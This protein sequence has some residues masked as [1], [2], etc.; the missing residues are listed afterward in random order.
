VKVL[1]PELSANQQLQCRFETEAQA[2]AKLQHPNIVQ[3][4]DFGQDTDNSLFIAMEFIDGQ[5]LRAVL[6]AEAPLRPARA[7]HIA[8]Q[9][10]ASL[11]EAHSHKIIHRD[12]KPDNVMLQQKGR[13]RD[14]AR[15]LDFGIA[16][17]RD[18]SRQTEATMT[19]AGDMLGTPQYMAPEQIRGDAIDARISA[20]R[21]ASIRS[22]SRRWRRIRAS[23]PRRWSTTPTCSLA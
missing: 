10:A 20:C 15:V 1:R 7:F 3:V 19:Q 2:V 4:F 12:L 18:D 5:S 21:L 13:Q 9:V 22:C 6:T 8:Q 16:K 17:L 11:I 23:A 14:V